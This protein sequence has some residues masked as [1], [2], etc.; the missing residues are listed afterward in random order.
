MHII[1]SPGIM[2]DRNRMFS[3]YNTDYTICF[4]DLVNFVQKMVLVILSITEKLPVYN[5][6][7]Q[8]INWFEKF[9]K[10]VICIKWKLDNNSV[11][12]T[13]IVLNVTFP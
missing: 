13:L 12:I 6:I 5:V 9:R 1:E 10:C 4:P 11:K 7:T 3:S 2:N 8:Q